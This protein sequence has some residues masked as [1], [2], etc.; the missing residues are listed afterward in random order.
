MIAKSSGL[1]CSTCKPPTGGC[2]I[3]NDK[4]INR[5]WNFLSE[6]YVY[7]SSILYHRLSS[8]PESFV[9]IDNVGRYIGNR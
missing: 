2:V 1:N 6:S 7:S 9:K 4:A 5:F 8:G 3:T